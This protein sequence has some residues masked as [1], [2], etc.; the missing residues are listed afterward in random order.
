MKEKEEKKSSLFYEHYKLTWNNYINNNKLCL[1]EKKFFNKETY[2][3]IIYLY[4]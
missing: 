1:K 4:K 2:I 3:Y